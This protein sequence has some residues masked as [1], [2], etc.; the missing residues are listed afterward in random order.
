MH[1]SDVL[2]ELITINVH[3]SGLFMLGMFAVTLACGGGTLRGV[4]L[5]PVYHILHVDVKQ[6]T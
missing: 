6:F 1:I 2:T 3:V 5:F 4:S